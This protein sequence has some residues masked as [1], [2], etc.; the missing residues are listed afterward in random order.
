MPALTISQGGCHPLSTACG[1]H[2]LVEL[3]SPIPTPTLSFEWEGEN[4]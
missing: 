3:N 2:Q 1:E 4:R